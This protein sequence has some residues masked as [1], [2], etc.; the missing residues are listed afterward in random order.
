MPVIDEMLVRRLVSTQFPE[1]A[2]LPVK[3]IVCGGMDNRSFRLGDE[4]VVRLPSA[5]AYAAQPEKESVWLPRLAPSLQLAIPPCVA[6]GQPAEG[7]PWRWSIYRWI[8]GESVAPEEVANSKVFAAGVA[9]F[10]VALQRI[11]AKGGPAPG[12]H[13][14]HRGGSLTAYDA[15]TRD[16]LQHL[17]W[18]IDTKAATALWAAA[19]R[20][21]WT[22]CPVWIHGDISVGNLLSQDNRLIGVIDFGNLGVGDPA[23]D[24][25]IAWTV[26]RGES[27]K[28]FQ[29]KLP[30]DPATWLR[31]RAWTLWKALIIAADLTQTN[32]V[33][34]RDPWTIIQQM[35]GET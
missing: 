35:M 8:E 14:F 26:F 4:M 24:L 31:A 16:A 10:L 9:D 15:E 1:W 32:A 7:Y 21:A 27:R 3:P 11:D 17:E 5:A 18:R 13:N 19:T 30:Y 2:H 28:A 34:W 23:C 29:S 20:T 33:E 22:H 6:L 25:S 12:A